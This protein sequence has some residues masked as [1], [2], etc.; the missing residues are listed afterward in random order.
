MFKNMGG[1]IKTLTKI[2]CWMGIIFWIIVGIV[3]VVIGLN[4]QNDGAMLMAIGAGVMVVGSLLSWIG[5]FFAYG[6]GELVDNS[7]IQ[8]ALLLRSEGKG[9]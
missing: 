1:K 7:A 6:F 2:T 8:T 5:S 9:R 3:L 4:A